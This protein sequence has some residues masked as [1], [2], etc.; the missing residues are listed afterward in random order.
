MVMIRHEYSSF[1]NPTTLFKADNIS[2]RFGKKSTVHS[3][4]LLIKYFLREHVCS[5]SK[6]YYS[7]NL[8]QLGLFI[9]FIEEN[10]NFSKIALLDKA[11]LIILWS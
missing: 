10:S 2:T 8:L 6:L 7:L 1:H 9:I 11:N 5:E 3:P 4:D